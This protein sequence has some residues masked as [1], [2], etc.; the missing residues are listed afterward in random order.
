MLTISKHKKLSKEKKKKKKKV[1]M[2]II[3]ISHMLP[4]HIII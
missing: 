1:F 4:K 2:A 3:V